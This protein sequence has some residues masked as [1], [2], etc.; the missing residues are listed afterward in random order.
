[1]LFAAAGL[2]SMHI[3]ELLYLRKAADHIHKHI[4][5]QRLKNANKY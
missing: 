3:S 2:R 4:E 1:M 5:T